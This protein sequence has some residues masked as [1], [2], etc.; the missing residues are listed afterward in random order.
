MIN[1]IFINLTIENFD[2]IVITPS[3]ANYDLFPVE[4][5]LNKLGRGCS[6]Y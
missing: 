3:K 2:R 6:F 1:L 4:S 5:N